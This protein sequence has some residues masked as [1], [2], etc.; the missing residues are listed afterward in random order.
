MVTIA[1]DDADFMMTMPKGL[2][3]ST[4]MDAMTHAVEAV[5]AKRA[6]PY[7]DKDALWA[8][9]T[10]K[11]Y[12][13][14]AVS[15]GGDVKAREMMAYAQY[16]AGM[17]FSNAGLGII[18]A[19]AHAL[20]GRFGL[21][22]GLCNAILLPYGMEF[23]GTD[24]ITSREFKKIAAALALPGA[25]SM[26]GFQ[27]STASAAYLREFSALLGLPQRL[28]DMEVNPEIFDELAETAME[29]SCMD[30]NPFKPT[31]EQ[32]EDVYRRAY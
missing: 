26:T 5:V 22:H 17:A 12:L 10:I 14:A 16:S 28:R 3:A 6:T 32:V 25:D 7:T 13:P 27:A 2:T 9:K 19:M 30:D 18:H 15:N 24:K 21:P 1:V 23:N 4:G 8:I 20:G 31:K 29:D 11:E